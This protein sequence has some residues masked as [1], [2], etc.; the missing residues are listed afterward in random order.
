MAQ[1][2][3]PRQG[4]PKAA[5][6][7]GAERTLDVDTASGGRPRSP[8]LG[9]PG[10]TTATG[11][12]GVLVGAGCWPG[13]PDG[14]TE[15]EGPGRAG[16]RPLQRSGRLAP[17]VQDTQTEGA[18]TSPSRRG[19]CQNP[20]HGPPALGGVSVG[21]RLSQ[22]RLGS[23]G[24]WGQREPPRCCLG[25]Q[26]QP[27][28]SPRGVRA[29]VALACPSPER[30]PAGSLP[31]VPRAQLCDPG[32]CSPGTPGSGPSPHM[33]A[34]VAASSASPSLHTRD[35]TLLVTLTSPW[36]GSY[37]IFPNLCRQQRKEGV[38]CRGC[39]GGVGTPAQRREGTPGGNGLVASRA[40]SW[41][42]G[43]AFPSQ[44]ARGQ[45]PAVHHLEQRRSH[46]WSLGRQP[47]PLP[48][49]GPQEGVGSPPSTAPRP[50]P[51][52]NLGSR[53]PGNRDLRQS[54]AGA[55]GEKVSMTGGVPGGR[56]ARCGS[57]LTPCH[58]L[59]LLQMDR[60]GPSPTPGGQGSRGGRGLVHGWS[61]TP[62]PMVLPPPLCCL[63]QPLTTFWALGPAQ[64]PSPAPRPHART[65]PEPRGH[66]VGIPKAASFH[67]HPLA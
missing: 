47:S 59:K 53:L 67:V 49:S 63:P 4:R 54:P 10:L 48:H 43:R 12:Q 37:R 29:S 7:V 33:A 5:G 3:G 25:R 6:C 61:P 42:A 62:E 36:R 35:R 24:P 55:G 8:P 52:Y 34:D 46:Q 51:K 1:P 31:C 11:P 18:S 22:A 66:R 56:A 27:R 32:P 44:S 19:A 40:R 39:P 28:P 26:R 50:Q 16:G 9:P 30:L 17:A 21:A 20:V 57:Y 41:E 45:W 58:S 15:A 65:H 60:E 23:A 38:S 14:H 2:L 64:V 13:L